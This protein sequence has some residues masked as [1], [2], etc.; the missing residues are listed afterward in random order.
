MFLGD[1]AGA[2]TQDPNIKSVV[3]YLLSY[4]VIV[5]PPFKGVRGIKRLQKYYF[6]RYQ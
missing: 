6:F 4:R 3:L 1:P 5:L 2:R